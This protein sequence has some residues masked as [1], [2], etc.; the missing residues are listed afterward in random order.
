MTDVPA[1]AMCGGKYGDGSAEECA[2]PPLWL[3]AIWFDG[4]TCIREG[5]VGTGG[6][7][8]LVPIAV[9]DEALVAAV[10]LGAAAV[11]PGAFAV[12]TAAPTAE[13]DGCL[14]VARTRGDAGTELRSGMARDKKRKTAQARSE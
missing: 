7:G 1:R 4:K 14:E 8:M 12:E 13:A 9:V 10:L 6:G 3:T 11:L 2:V 5:E